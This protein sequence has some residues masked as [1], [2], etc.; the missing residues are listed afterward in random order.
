MLNQL[1]LVAWSCLAGLALAFPALADDGFYIGGQGGVNFT[2]DMT[3]S[4]PVGSP[5]FRTDQKA[6]YAAGFVLGYDF[7]H[8]SSEFEFTHRDNDINT[9]TIVNDG[10]MGVALGVGAFAPGLLPPARG[11]VRSNAFM[12][13]LYYNFAPEKKFNPFVGLGVGVARITLNGVGG[14]G[15]SVPAFI[16]GQ[17]DT[18]FAA[19]GIAGFRQQLSDAVYLV[20]SYRYTHMGDFAAVIPT[21][22][23]VDPDV[24]NH[25]IMLGVI[26]KFGQPKPAP[27]PAP[28]AAPPPPPPP[29]A[30]VVA[31]APRTIPGPFIVFFD[32]D[33]DGLD[34]QAMAI[35]REAAAAF[36]EYGIA[37]V[38]AIGHADRSGPEAYNEGLASR[39]SQSVLGVFVGLGIPQ[40]AIN[41]EGRGERE[42]R[43]PTVDGVRERQNRRVEI[44]LIE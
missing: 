41:I 42:N 10:G 39:R 26:V 35:L 31:P 37:R 21:G 22:A 13:N 43:V 44:T 11:D 20:L 4:G 16:A 27:A 19:Q 30:P 15:P 38:V 6:G 34:E 24:N 23:V 8:W 1:R 2:P 5:L 25:T 7:G 36:R 9:L 17:K 40:A 12:W 29:P 28:V 18:N 14:G 3:F 32:W 33:S